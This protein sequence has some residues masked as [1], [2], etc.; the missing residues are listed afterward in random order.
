MTT[1]KI[2]PS[3]KQ[4]KNEFLSHSKILDQLENDTIFHKM[5]TNKLNKLFHETGELS[6]E[7]LIRRTNEKIDGPKASCYKII[8]DRTSNLFKK[9]VK[10]KVDDLVRIVEYIYEKFGITEEV[11]AMLQQVS[12]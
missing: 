5:T 4:L 1:T 12:D 7:F 9:N 11:Q 10:N 6:S 2:I 8:P 3:A